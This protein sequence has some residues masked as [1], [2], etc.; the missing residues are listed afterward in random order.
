MPYGGACHVRRLA[1]SG[2]GRKAFERLPASGPH[3]L[4]IS[5]NRATKAC[6]TRLRLRAEQLRRD[7]RAFVEQMRTRNPAHADTLEARWFA[8][9]G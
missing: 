8:L 5:A 9:A 1:D 6:A 2:A 4:V 3:H 7:R